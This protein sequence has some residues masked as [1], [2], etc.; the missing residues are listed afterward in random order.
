MHRNS[1]D[2]IRDAADDIAY[3]RH[4]RVALTAAYTAVAIAFAVLGFVTDDPPLLGKLL[5]YV[6][7]GVIF[8]AI[9]N[10]FTCTRDVHNARRVA[11]SAEAGEL[12]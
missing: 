9:A 3:Y 10:V 1:I 12:D 5:R 11:A 2:V 8:L 7:G 6:A 4:R